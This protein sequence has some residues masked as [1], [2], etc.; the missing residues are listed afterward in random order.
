MGSRQDQMLRIGEHGNLALRRTSP[1]HI[2]NG[3][4]LPV[5][6]GDHR[7]RELLPALSLMGKCRDEFRLPMCQA[8]ESTVQRLKKEMTA[9]GIL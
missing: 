1:E 9:Y 6:R 7:V 2:H 5:D 8:E 3:T 4:V